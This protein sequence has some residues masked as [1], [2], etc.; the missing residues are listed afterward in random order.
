MEMHATRDVLDVRDA[1]VANSKFDDVNLSNTR[2]HNVNLSAAVIEKVNL[3]N[4]KIEDVNLSNV[5]F[6]NVN[7][8]NVKIESALLAGM[9]NG[10]SV[11]D[12]FAAYESAN[13]AGE[14]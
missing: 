13:R 14:E 5:L 6:R 1:S 4:S 11:K 3:S 12:L 7:M 8:S 2:F 9:I 10:V